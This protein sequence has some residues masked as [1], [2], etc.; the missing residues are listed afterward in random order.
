VEASEARVRGILTRASGYLR[1]VCSHSLQP[2]R[3]CSYGHSLCGVSC[4][5]Q[6][7]RWLTRGAEWGSFLEARVNAAEV[8]L[9]QAARERRWGRKARGAFSI[10]LSSSTDPFVPQE[11]KLGIT[12]SV[13]EAMLQEP[14]DEL[15]LQTHS[16]RVVDY[17]DLY[18]TL[19]ERCGLRVQISVESDRDR[20]P[21]LPPP[22][23]SVADRLAAA[24]TLRSAGLR[25][26]V[27]VSPLL[28][29][30]DPQ[31]FFA[32]IAEVADACVIDHFV[33]GDG[34]PDGSRTRKTALP[35]AMEAVEP[36][37]SDLP[38]RDRIVAIAREAMPGRVGV[39]REGFAGRYA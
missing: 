34:T 7:N 31:A 33:E 19:G 21:G 35:E 23:S 27:T 13:L 28:P 24:E 1:D 16:H 3:G 5:V 25:V 26:V 8:Y 6:H 36:G 2:Y 14:P 37:S 22:A 38:Y 30:A 17:V 29:I 32:R 11:R 18:S 10:F 4:Y 12:R 20:L 15:I 39:S 9:G